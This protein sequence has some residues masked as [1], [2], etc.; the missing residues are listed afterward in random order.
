MQALNTGLLMDCSELRS[1]GMAELRY[2]VHPPCH[3]R[4]SGRVLQKR[5]VSNENTA[6]GCLGDLLRMKNYTVK[7][8]F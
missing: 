1:H 4:L 8:G 6:F 2:V 3:V 7:W 5:Q